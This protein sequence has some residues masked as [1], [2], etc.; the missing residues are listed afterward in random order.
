MTDSY[1]AESNTSK[2]GGFMNSSKSRSESQTVSNR[3]T[4]VT[5]GGSVTLTAGTDLTLQAAQVTAGG[6]LSL[7]AG[8]TLSLLSATDSSYLSQTSSKSSAA[9]QS[10]SDKGHNDTTVVMTGLQAGGNLSVNA[11]KVVADYKSTGDLQASLT[12]LA[13]DPKTA[14][15]AQLATKDAV[16]WQAVQE[17]HKK[18]DHESQGLSAAAS[19]IIAIVVAAVTAGTG[20]AAMVAEEAASIGLVAAGSDA[21]LAVGAAGAA[22]FSTLATQA[23]TSLINNQGDLGKTLQELGSL[24]TVKNIAISM[25]SAGAFSEVGSATD[26]HGITMDKALDDP[27]NYAAN[28][29]GHATVGCAMGA[30]SGGSCGAGAASAAVSAAATPAYGN[31]G[32]TAGTAVSAAIGGATASITGGSAAQGA[33]T[34]AFGYLF[35]WLG[36]GSDGKLWAVQPTADEYAAHYKEGT[37]ETVYRSGDDVNLAEYAPIQFDVQKGQVFSVYPSSAALAAALVNWE[38]GTLSPGALTDTFIYGSL[39]QVTALG[40][41][42]VQLAPDTFNFNMEDGRSFR[43]WMTQVQ[44][45]TLGGGV[46][47][48]DFRTI[49]VGQTKAP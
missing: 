18:W 32:L 7:S 4:S 14:W 16:T 25:A 28:V 19:A 29:A 13:A 31:A 30:A 21:A 22:G 3:G 34:G 40:S 45:D 26:F 48:K 20:L 8:G 9:W 6:D 15:V 27:L 44:H 5:A 37:G 33:V 46:P 35:N 43:N 17:A 38:L 24:D 36:R 41:G 49:F 42:Y 1:Y 2:S 47:G 10:A 39:G 12:A 23:T 11:A